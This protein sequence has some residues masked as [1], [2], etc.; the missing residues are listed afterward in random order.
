MSF[1]IDSHCHIADSRFAA[2]LNPMIEEAKMRGISYFIQ[3]GIGPE[4]WDRQLIL[5]EKYKNQIGLCFGL[6]PY[7]VVDHSLQECEEALDLL[8]LK[9]PQALLLGELGLDFRPRILK[10]T[11]ESSESSM[12]TAKEKQISIFEMQLELAL[13]VRKP[14]VLHLV[15]AHEEGLLILDLY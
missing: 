14:F 8:A 12:E 2:F 9:V 4:D 3:G 10:S 6:H 13:S 11:E 1:W 7:W 5:A 15:Q